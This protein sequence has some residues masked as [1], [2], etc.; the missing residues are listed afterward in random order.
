MPTT[1]LGPTHPANLIGATL[2]PFAYMTACCPC[3]RQPWSSAQRF[4]HPLHPPTHHAPPSPPQAG[5]L[6]TL[7]P[8][9]ELHSALP[10]T[11]TAFALSLL[12][13]F[14]TNSSYSRWL[15]AR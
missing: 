12:L 3:W 9:V 4:L 8:A 10:F 14:R 7:E 6:P 1:L 5:L 15:D 2:P 13:V 11:L